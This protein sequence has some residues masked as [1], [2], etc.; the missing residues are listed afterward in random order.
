MKQLT[1]LLGVLFALLITSCSK[2]DES[3]NNSI[4]EYST[5]DFVGK[6][7]SNQYTIAVYVNL[8][9]DG[10]GTMADPNGDIYNISWMVGTIITED[11]DSEGTVAETEY[12]GVIATDTDG[13]EYYYIVSSEGNDIN[14]IT[15]IYNN[16]VYSKTSDTDDDVED[17]SNSVNLET[18][19]SPSDFT[20]TDIAKEKVVLSF[21]YSGSCTII[22]VFNGPKT[23]DA[24]PLYTLTEITEG[25]N[26]ITIESLS[27][28]TDYLLYIYACNSNNTD[29]QYSTDEVTVAFT[30][31]NAIANLAIDHFGFHD[32]GNGA[33]NLGVAVITSDLV[34]D[35]SEWTTSGDMIFELY[36][37]NSRE[38]GFQLAESNSFLLPDWN[39]TQVIDLYAWT[40]DWGYVE[41]NTYYLKIIAKN[42]SGEIVGESYIQ[43]IEYP[44][45]NDIIPSKPSG[46]TLTLNDSC[47]NIS[48]NSADN[49]VSY[50]IY[51]S[52][53][54]SMT[55]R[56]KVGETTETT[57]SDCDRGTNVKMYYQ[58]VAVSSTGNKI[59]SDPESIWL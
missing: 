12:E 35:D 3:N 5:S 15:D 48:W 30:T 4:T 55:Y 29:K 20:T 31:A 11:V 22:E 41:G 40:D 26:T 50:E 33:L 18:P 1:I 46:V 37:S 43:E 21:N 23:S 25:T 2:D 34:D 49:A 51:V 17:D 14:E 6:W 45:S 36:T 38:D 9:S 44:T 16:I 19:N 39:N 13:Y 8:D 59:Y 10:T 7:E 57:M 58:V 52:T 28:G 32:Q 47:V 24:L 27:P 42:K 56:T 54:S 53:S